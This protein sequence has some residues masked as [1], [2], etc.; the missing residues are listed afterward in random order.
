LFSGFFV[1][2]LWDGFK[3]VRGGGR[4]GPV[5]D[6]GNNGEKGD[7]E[8]ETTKWETRRRIV[9]QKKERTR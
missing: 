2:K 5:F 6:D 7:G 8:R 1:K 4:E 9:V 3:V